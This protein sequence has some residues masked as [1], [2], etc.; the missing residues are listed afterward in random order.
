MRTIE[1][2]ET[3]Y[4]RLEGYSEGFRDT[5]DKVINKAL[6]ALDLQNKNITKNQFIP[7]PMNTQLQFESNK[8][9]D[10][11]FSKPL[12][13]KIDGVESST[14]KWVELLDPILSIAIDRGLSIFDLKRKYAFNIT[15]DSDDH[16]HYRFISNLGIWIQPLSSKD[17]LKR[18]QKIAQ[19]LQIELEIVVKWLQNDKAQFPGMEAKIRI[20]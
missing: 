9:P 8:I 1:I 12:S 14:R 19:D 15:E 6:D 7:K 11:S 17:V 20:N 13:M 16:T 5:E 4:E 3:T 18:V 2:S 10:V